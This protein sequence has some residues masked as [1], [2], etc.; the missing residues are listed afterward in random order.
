[1][2]I[3]TICYS[4]HV[5][6]QGYF[7]KNLPDGMIMIKDGDK[8]FIGRPVTAMEAEKHRIQADPE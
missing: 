3:K 5:F 2:T 7:V 6:A 4:E 8:T 1:M